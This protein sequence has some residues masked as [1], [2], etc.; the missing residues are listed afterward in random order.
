MENTSVKIMQCVVADSGQMKI[1]CI[2]V[3][4]GIFLHS[5]VKKMAA[6]LHV[7]VPHSTT[8]APP[9]PVK[10]A[11]L[12]VPHALALLQEKGVS[13][14]LSVAIA[15][16]ASMEGSSAG[17][18]MGSKVVEAV[19]E[20]LTEANL[21]ITVDETGGSNIRSMTLDVETGKVDIT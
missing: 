4:V 13:D 17:S 10:F 3:G 2:G 12:A 19:K 9:N 11:N 6:G 7:L 18:S 20:A 1:D 5:H 15:G 16:G 21:N 8:P 14:S